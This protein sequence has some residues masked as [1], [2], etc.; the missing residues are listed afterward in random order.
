[1]NLI[2]ENNASLHSFFTYNKILSVLVSL[3]H[4]VLVGRIHYII[5]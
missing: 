5:L 3:T 2:N 4:A 1:M